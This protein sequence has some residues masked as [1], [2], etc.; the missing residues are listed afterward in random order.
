MNIIIAYRARGSHVW[1]HLFRVTA[2]QWRGFHRH[3]RLSRKYG[4][5]A[6]VCNGTYVSIL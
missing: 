5:Y 1:T 3:A 4:E 2:D 6:R